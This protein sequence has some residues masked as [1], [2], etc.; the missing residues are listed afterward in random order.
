MTPKVKIDDYITPIKRILSDHKIDMKS[1]LHK[2]IYRAR[3]INHRH[4]YRHSVNQTVGRLLEPSWPSQ[5]KTFHLDEWRNCAELVWRRASKY[6]GSIPPPELVIF[7]GFGRFNGRVYELDGRVV[8]GCSPDFPNTTGKNLEVLL[9]H[10][11]AHFLRWRITGISSDNVPVYAMTYEEGWATWFSIR[12][13][14]GFDLGDIFMSKLHKSI[15]MPNPKSG[16][17]RWCRKNL[18]VV[19]IAAQKVLDSKESGDLGRFFQCQR[20]AGSKT[21]IRVGYYLGYRMIEM[22][23]RRLAIRELLRIRPKKNIIAAWLKE[24]AQYS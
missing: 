1:E 21:P 14:P 8:I 7:P 6:L 20:Y 5:V 19:A 22:L 23:S 9:A 2:L 3:R 18:I 10:E 24:L 15:N 12:L 4:L 13:L 16:Y 17:F 11:Y